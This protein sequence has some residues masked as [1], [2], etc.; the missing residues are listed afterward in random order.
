MQVRQAALGGVLA[1]ALIIG[2]NA[3]PAAPA[4]GQASVG[5]IAPI[6]RQTEAV[7]DG[8]HHFRNAALDVVFDAIGALIAQAKQF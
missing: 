6:D 3:S 2:A 7:F 4:G 1:A 5:A 8:L